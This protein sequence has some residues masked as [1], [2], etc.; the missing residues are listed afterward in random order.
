MEDRSS[1]D[2]RIPKY[3]DAARRISQGEY[4]VDIPL[5]PS[6]EIGQLGETLLE[7]ARILEQRYRELQTLEQITTHINAGLLLD[8]ILDLVYKEFSGVI[9]YNRIGL[10]LV[11]EDDSVV[12]A[13]W[14]KSDQPK[15]YL[16]KGYSAQLVG[17]SLEKI[18]RTGQPRILNDLGDYL[19]HKPDSA[20][21]RL[22]FNEGIRSSLTCPLIANG[23]PIG[24]IFFSSTEP[25]T[26]AGVHVETF[27]KIAGQLSVILEKGRL[28]SELADQKLAI[29]K[30]NAELQRLNDQHNKFLSIAAHDLRS[31]LGF[32]QMAVD[33]LSGQNGVQYAKHRDVLLES[34]R[35]QTHRMLNLLNNL[36][37][38]T[39]IEAGKLSINPES[40]ELKGFLEEVVQNHNILAASK[41]IRIML[42]SPAICQANADPIRL[43][44]AV[45]NLISNAVK[46][47]PPGSQVQVRVQQISSSWRISIKDQGP[48]ILPGDR[49][50]LFEAF[51]RLSTVPTGGE[52]ST[53]LGLAIV[54]WVVEAHG[55]RIGVDSEPGNGAEF[56]FTLPGNRDELDDSPPGS[57]TSPSNAGI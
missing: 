9:P 46:Y 56:W 39:E 29:E 4:D 52:K 51:S 41:K 50:K 19:T 44:Q 6:D 36:L 23:I 34:I 20:S 31:P 57:K 47:S 11:E 54:R 18:I 35:R 26:Y 32:V 45:D 40:I 37:N 15:I 28:I 21:T 5:T 24:F 53:G 12:R 48:G 25:F 17:S 14:A 30:K 2:S 22:I 43:R 49:Q 55:G 3:I 16:K 8:E 33:L 42:D 7:L 10:A 27:Q 1:P 38:F 13:Y